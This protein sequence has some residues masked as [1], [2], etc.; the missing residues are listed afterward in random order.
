MHPLQRKILNLSKTVNLAPITLR[1]IGEK[2]GEPSP[3]NPQKIKHHI[4]QLLKK[5][6]LKE[7][8]DKTKISPIKQGDSGLFHSIPILGSVNCGQAL[9]FAE[10]N[11]E[12]YLKVSK[13]T[14]PNFKKG[15]IF[16]I[17]AIGNSMNK[18][19]ISGNSL[20][21]G[22]YAIVDKTQ[23]NKNSYINKYVLSI[24]DGMANIKKL[25]LDKANKGYAL[26]SQSSQNHPPIYIHENDFSTY[27]ISGHVVKVI[28]KP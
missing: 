15:K 28:K 10:E 7:N 16:A 6:F 20:Q 1:H 27:K 9:T 18:A 14:I 21:N 13:S 4:N 3:Q 24:I 2:V 22:D 19:D 11:F 12:G 5:G 17:K 25:T 26:L 8:A 23:L